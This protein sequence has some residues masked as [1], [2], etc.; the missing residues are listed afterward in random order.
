MDLQIYS[1]PKIH[2]IEKIP[3]ILWTRSSKKLGLEYP[4]K[5]FEKVF[6]VI[7]KD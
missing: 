5:G 1:K 7:K 2:R 3:L 6:W 4:L